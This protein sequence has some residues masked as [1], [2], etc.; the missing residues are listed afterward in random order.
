MQINTGISELTFPVA[1]ALHPGP[2]RSCQ[3]PLLISLADMALAITLSEKKD[4]NEEKSFVRVEPQGLG[5]RPPPV[6]PSP[7]QAPPRCPW[8]SSTNH[9]RGSAPPPWVAMGTPPMASP[10]PWV[11]LLMTS[12]PRPRDSIGY[13]EAIVSG[14]GDPP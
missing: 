6:S 2:Q 13:V 9:S 4:L 14:L 8:N 1:A 10:E 7:T 12:C 3:Y 5:R 11:S